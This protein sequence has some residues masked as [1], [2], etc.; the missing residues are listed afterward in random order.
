MAE[1]KLLNTVINKVDPVTGRQLVPDRSVSE[2][3]A[4]EHGDPNNDNGNT[5]HSIEK[6][7]SAYEESQ[8]GSPKKL[9]YEPHLIAAEGAETFG[10]KEGEVRGT[11]RMDPRFD[12][13]CK[14][15]HDASKGKSRASSLEEIVGNRNKLGSSTGRPTA[16]VDRLLKSREAQM[17]M[18][19]VRKSQIEA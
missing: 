7:P 3:L 12:P 1:R 5:L 13:A 17:S 11:F 6:E 10:R 4:T 9:R 16:L 19:S 8:E 15:I 2:M 18:I 14:P